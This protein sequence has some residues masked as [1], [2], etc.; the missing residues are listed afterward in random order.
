MLL[1]CLL[2][3]TGCSSLEGTGDKGYI[4]GNG[5]IIQY[6]PAD[7]GDPIV[8]TGDSLDGDP[9]DLAD[10][11]G[12][13]VVVNVWWSACAPCRLE[14]PVLVEAAAEVKA[15][16]SFLGIN[17]RDNS[18]EPA[19]AFMKAYGAGYPSIYD[20]SG[21]ALLAFAG[22]ISPRTIPTTVL[23]D[24]QGRVAATIRGEVPTKLTLTELVEE[25]AAEDG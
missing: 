5:Q 2:A 23:L 12:K 9:I 15:D 4:S 20:P 1:A 16:A 21:R 14:T 10:R 3:L 7:R 17:I 13:V 25:V 8:L 18:V 24:R 19:Q 6:R 11:R 22:R